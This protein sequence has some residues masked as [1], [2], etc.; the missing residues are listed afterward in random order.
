MT[1]LV[2]ELRKRANVALHDTTL[3][4]EPRLRWRFKER[5]TTFLEAIALID[6]DPL[7]KAAPKMRR[8][9]GSLVRTMAGPSRPLDEVALAK[10]LLA[11]L[12]E[13]KKP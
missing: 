5:E 6:A 3:A 1:D 13:E 10:E 12:P 2:A 4:D 11:T 9:L 8:I 7:Y